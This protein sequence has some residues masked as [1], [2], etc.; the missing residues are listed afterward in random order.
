MY[1]R[2]NFSKKKQ[3]DVKDDDFPVL[4]QAIIKESKLNFKDLK[5]PDE[6][7]EEGKIKEGW[8]KLYYKNNKIIREDNPVKKEKSKQTFKR[9]LTLEEEFCQT[10][11]KMRERWENYNMEKGYEVD[12]DFYYDKNEYESESDHELSS[13]R[14][15]Y[16]DM[17][18][19]LIENKYYDD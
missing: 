7:E 10:I 14:D 12:Y 17:N 16:Y 3:F 8:T 6:D 5:N 4:T 13:D 15:D 9:E 1:R 11:L 18:E 2:G 19:Y